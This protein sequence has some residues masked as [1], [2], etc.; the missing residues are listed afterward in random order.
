MRDGVKYHLTQT[1]FLFLFFPH[2]RVTEAF[3][4]LEHHT[5]SVLLLLHLCQLLLNVGAFGE[6][7]ASLFF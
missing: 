5:V 6:S 3:P 4:L 2:V 1:A 7:R